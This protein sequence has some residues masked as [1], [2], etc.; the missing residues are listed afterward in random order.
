MKIKIKM[1]EKRGR[2]FAFHRINCY[3]TKRENYK[4]RLMLRGFVSYKIFQIDGET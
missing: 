2:N 1:E 3:L 4:E